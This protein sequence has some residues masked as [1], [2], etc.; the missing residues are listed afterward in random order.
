MNETVMTLG[1]VI[2]ATNANGRIT[3]GANHGL[4]RTYKWDSQEVSVKLRNRDKRWNGSFG[5]YSP[6][7]GGNIHTV[8]EEGQQHFSSEKEAIE[9]LSWQEKT[10]HYVY[11]SNGLVVGWYVTKDANSPS[12]ALSVQVWQFYIQGQKPSQLSGARDDLFTVD[13]KGGETSSE[14]VKPGD[15]KPSNP[16]T[17]N[18]RAYSGKSMD[19]MHVLAQRE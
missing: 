9:W 10:M 2:K 8:V 15:F 13:Y 7:G 5:I 11:S 6:G 3:I 14:N 4:E 17:I 12:Q 19:I 16:K 1:M 18:N